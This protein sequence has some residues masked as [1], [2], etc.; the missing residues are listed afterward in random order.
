MTNYFFLRLKI[1]HTKVY[2]NSSIIQQRNMK[3]NVNSSVK[4]YRDKL[5]RIHKNKL[6]WI[7]DEL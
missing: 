4:N 1:L 7:I 2:G 3:I 5:E 6:Q